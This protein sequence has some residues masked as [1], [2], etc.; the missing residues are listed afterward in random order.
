MLVDYWL[1]VS[2]LILSILELKLEMSRLFVG[3]LLDI[4]DF[5]L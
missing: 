3:L 2:I 1:E 4:V 5:L